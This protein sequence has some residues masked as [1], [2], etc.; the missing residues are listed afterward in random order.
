MHGAARFFSPAWRCSCRGLLAQALL[1]LEQFLLRLFFRELFEHAHDLGE[2]TVVRLSALRFDSLR[3]LGHRGS[4]ENQT[5]WQVLVEVVAKTRE[6][7][8]GDERVAAELEKA[9]VS[10]N[11]IDT[12]Q[13]APN[14]SDAFLGW[15][16][17][18][19][20]SDP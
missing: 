17:R 12:Q 19:D 20:V 1:P 4:F 14:L 2:L 13:L 6:E 18:C 7:A 11:L 16:T 9:V 3:Q 10:T 5:Q 15:R 8:D